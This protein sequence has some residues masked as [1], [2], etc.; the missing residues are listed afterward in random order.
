[1]K[2]IICTLLVAIFTLSLCGCSEN[3]KY[4]VYKIEIDS[5]C[6]SNNHVGNEWSQEYRYDTERIRDGDKITAELNSEIAIWATI[7]EKDKYSDTGEKKIVIDLSESNSETA[8]VK[9]VERGGGR[10]DGNLAEWEV[11]ITAKLVRKTNK[12]D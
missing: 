5:H 2:K 1:M 9:V 4:G 12:K 6:V 8:Y 7:T 3:Y 11:T 10:Y